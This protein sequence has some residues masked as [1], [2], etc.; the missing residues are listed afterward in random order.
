MP[1]YIGTTEIPESSGNI[2]M[3]NTSVSEIYMGTTR[4]WQ[5]TGAQARTFTLAD[6]GISFSV[7][8]A[9]TV[10]LAIGT[11]TLV[12]TNFSNGQNL[13]TVSSATTRTLT[14]SVRVP[15]DSSPWTNANSLIAISG[16]SFNQPVTTTPVD[17]TADWS[18][19]TLGT[20]VGGT[21]SGVYTV[22]TFADDWM[23]LSGPASQEMI[24]QTR[25]ATVTE[26]YD[27]ASRTDTRTCE[28][29]TNPSG[30][31]SDGRC[32]SP[33]SAIGG[34]DTPNTPLSLIH[35]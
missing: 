34:T 19:Y 11:G 8:A 22:G 31:G 15:N 21:A 7:S 18:G 26:R 3:G 32:S 24:T 6:A 16:I 2:Q 13:G 27:N 5:A 30:G 10:S 33:D 14:G 9:G 28:V 17:G 25:S 35:I 12:S 20:V 1:I 23:P 29:L 4:I